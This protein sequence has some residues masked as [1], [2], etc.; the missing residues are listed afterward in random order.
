MNSKDVLFDPTA[1]GGILYEKIR[2][3]QRKKQAIRKRYEQYN[4]HVDEDNE[5]SEEELEAKITE[6]V[7]FF[8]NILLP[9][10]RSSL[11]TKLEESAKLRLTA[12]RMEKREAYDSSEKLYLV[13]PELIAK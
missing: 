3:Q 4:E 6:L 13:D 7:D 9:R 2:Y 10:D 8:G 12:I 5:I 1:R 11:L